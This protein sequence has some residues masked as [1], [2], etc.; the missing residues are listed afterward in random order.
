M[1]TT[2][3]IPLTNGRTIPAGTTLRAATPA[4][5]ARVDPCAWLFAGAKA[6]AYVFDGAVLL[7]A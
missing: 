4:E 5:A 3:P 6:R 2:R 7:V 1:T